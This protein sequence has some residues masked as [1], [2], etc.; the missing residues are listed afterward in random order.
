MSK[1]PLIVC[2]MTHNERGMDEYLI[3]IKRGQQ[4]GCCPLFIAGSVDDSAWRYFT[5]LDINGGAFGFQL[6]F[7]VSRSLLG[8]GGQHW[9]WRTFH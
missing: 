4:I 6:G 2:Y 9:C 3:A 7:G 8:D 1:A 5:L